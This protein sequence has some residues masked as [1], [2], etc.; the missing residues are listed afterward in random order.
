MKMYNG[1][2]SIVDHLF[3]FAL[4]GLLLV[5]EAKVVGS[6]WG[7]YARENPDQHRKNVDEIIGYLAD[8]SIKPR[9]DTMVS[10]ENFADAFEVFEQNKGR[11][12]TVICIKEDGPCHAKL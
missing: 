11:G 4:L 6:L 10:F 3:S 12:N 9:V 5:K 2:N 7:R 8:G 1:R